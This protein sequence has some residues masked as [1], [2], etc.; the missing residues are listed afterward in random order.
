MFVFG[1]FVFLSFQCANKINKSIFSIKTFCSCDFLSCYN[2][3]V[4]F[5]SIDWLIFQAFWIHISIF[6]FFFWQF[7]FFLFLVN[8]FQC[9]KTTNSVIVSRYLIITKTT[10]DKK[11][12]D[13][14]FS[15]INLLYQ[16]MS[17]EETKTTKRWWW[18][19]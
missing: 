11:H 2:R 12:P 1:G 5:N 14:L 4:I 8:F 9:K 19:K 18:W 6:L 7:F 13:Q 17:F 15:L 10:N 3:S 16:I